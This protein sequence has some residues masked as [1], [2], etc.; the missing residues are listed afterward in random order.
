MS[1]YNVGDKVVLINEDS[2]YLQGFKGNSGI[3]VR[4]AEKTP[5]PYQ[6]RFNS[7]PL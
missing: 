6:V 5:C 7:I 1:E 2:F 3:V 4:V